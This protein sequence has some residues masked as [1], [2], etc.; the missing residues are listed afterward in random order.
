[1]PQ[2][3][4]RVVEE[5]W[6]SWCGH[7]DHEP[8][9]AA[10]RAAFREGLGADRLLERLAGNQTTPWTDA[11]S[12][13]AIDVLRHDLGGPEEAHR[14][15]V[16]LVRK[17]ALEP[18]HAARLAQ[19]ALDPQRAV[20][21]W[22]EIAQQTAQPVERAT[23]YADISTLYEETLGQ[24]GPAIEAALVSFMA[25][26]VDGVPFRR[27]VAHYEARTRWRDVL[28]LYDVLLHGRDPA[29]PAGDDH[30]ALLLVEKARVEEERMQAPDRAAR[31]L[32][33]ALHLQ[34]GNAALLSLLR[35]RVA[36]RIADDDL[37]AFVVHR[38]HAL[39]QA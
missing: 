27:L 15:L 2:R 1:M 18:L 5:R 9:Q 34:P 14:C 13:L 25:H 28:G 22:E 30:R 35:D 31:T 26:E 17:Q 39:V 37:R 21:V 8:T 10:L 24:P 20:L 12:A 33:E 4:D 3:D 19:G 16:D 32:L 23:L 7:P 29:G 38:C 36:P 6:L 11:A